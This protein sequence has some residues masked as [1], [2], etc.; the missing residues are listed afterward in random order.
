MKRPSEGRALSAVVSPVESL[1][2]VLSP[3]TPLPPPL[4]ADRGLALA[5]PLGAGLLVEPALSELRVETR[6]L[7][8]ALE[9][10]QCP[11]ETL[12]VMYH[13]FQGDHAPYV[14]TGSEKSS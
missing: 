10:A 13:D 12:V 7:D 8:F 14:V 4:S 3:H 5:L 9:P 11:L 1:R 2:T 6:T